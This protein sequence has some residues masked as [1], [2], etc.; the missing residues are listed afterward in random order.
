[1]KCAKS[2]LQDPQEAGFCK[3]RGHTLILPDGKPPV[4]KVT[5]K[6]EPSEIRWYPLQDAA[7]NIPAQLL[8]IHGTGSS[9]MTISLRPFYCLVSELFH[10]QQR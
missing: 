8:Q 5:I 3:E 4:R 2:E 7:E 9:D 10:S 6:R 1:M